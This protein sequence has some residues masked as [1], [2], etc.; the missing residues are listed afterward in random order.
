MV[1]RIAGHSVAESQAAPP[2]RRAKA[3][4]EPVF[5]VHSLDSV[6]TTV[7]AHGGAMEPR[8]K[9]WSFNGA[10]VCDGVDPEGNVIQ[11]REVGRS[12]P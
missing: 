8:E 10:A 2:T 7:G 6:R 4:F 9:E 11:V 12:E 5:F 1:H 3:S